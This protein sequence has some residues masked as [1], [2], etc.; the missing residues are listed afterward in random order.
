MMGDAVAAHRRRSAR[1]QSAPASRIEA[2]VERASAATASSVGEAGGHRERVARER[3]GLIDRAV[4]RKIRH[5]VGA[6]AERRRPA[7]RRR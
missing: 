5:D 3:P 6:A 1:R 4:G 2:I 7:A